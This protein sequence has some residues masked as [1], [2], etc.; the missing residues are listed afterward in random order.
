MDRLSE[1]LHLTSH[2]V[3]WF[4]ADLVW[5]APSMTAI[6]LVEYVI[7]A[8]VFEE[9]A[10]RGLLFAILRRKFR[11]LP[12]AL[13]SASIFAIAHGYGLVGFISVLWS[14]VLWAWLYEKTGSL[15]PGIL[16][17]TINNLLVCLAVMALLR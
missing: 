8:P 16:A 3:E 2:W 7:F 15:L 5:A 13:I 11:F 9:L 4:D 1:P 12:A 17:H 6:S 14:G 10:F